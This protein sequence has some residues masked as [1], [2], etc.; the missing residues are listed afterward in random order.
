MRWARTVH[1]KPIPLDPEP[2]PYGNLDLRDGIAHY[3]ADDE[4]AAHEGPLY[5]AHFV[6]C[7]NAAQHRK[8]KR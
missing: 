4:A 8:A 6:T 1:D 5:L 2:H 7:P 3:L